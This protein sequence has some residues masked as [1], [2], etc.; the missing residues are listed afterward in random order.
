MQGT[1]NRVKEGE[2]RKEGEGGSTGNRKDAREHR[3]ESSKV[4]RE[5]W[6]LQGTLSRVKEG[7]KGT[8]RVQGNIE[9]SPVRSPGNSGGCREHCA[10]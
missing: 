1:L 6:R 3:T 2:H 10:E 9:Q 5:Q 8:E 7:S 4:A